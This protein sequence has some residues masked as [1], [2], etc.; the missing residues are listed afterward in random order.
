MDPHV[1]LPLGIYSASVAGQGTDGIAT[2]H[3]NL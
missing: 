2:K 3:V 1:F